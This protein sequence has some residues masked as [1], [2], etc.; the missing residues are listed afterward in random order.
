MSSSFYLLIVAAGSGSRFGGEVPKQYLEICGKSVLRRTIEAFLT[1]VPPEHIHIVINPAHRALYDKAVAGL[2]LPPPVS[3]GGERRDSVSNGISS[4]SGLKDDDILLIH[5]A[6]RPFIRSRDIS[7]LVCSLEGACSAAT[8][9]VPVSDT[10]RHDENGKTVDRSGLW[11]IQT[12]QAFRLRVIRQ[13]HASSAEPFTDDAG[14]M[15][16]IGVPVKMVEGTRDNFKITTPKDW[17]LAQDIIMRM[18][19][20][21]QFRTGLGFDVH[22]FDPSRQNVTLCGVE[23]PCPAALSGHSDA[24]AGLHALTDALLGTIG[25]GDIGSFFPPS[26]P[27]WKGADSRTFVEKALLLV[28]EK[29]GRLVNV[30]VTFICEMPKIGPY[31][32]AMQ[33]K[34]GVLLDLA[35]DR[36]GIKATT[37]EAMG[38]TGRKE[39]LAAQAIVSVE[40]PA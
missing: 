7:S 2:D 9:A 35:A 17:L 27:Q 36:I 38:F 40:F 3:G 20:K 6:A 19:E 4:F 13:A 8:L 16:A 26:D 29:G 14:M 30:D 18:E 5:D 28:R 37:S 11:S 39:G 23:L 15:A 31:R 22:R 1:L 25:A 34:L 21:T 33:Q 24:D 32:Q 10:L 12:P